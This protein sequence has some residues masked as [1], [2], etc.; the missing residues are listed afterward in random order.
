MVIQELVSAYPKASIILVSFA[1]TLVMTLIT[2]HLTDQRRIKE[3]RKRAKEHQAK[4]KEIRKGGDM[5]EMKK[6]QSLMMEENMELMRHSMK[7][8]MY[9]AIPLLLVF[10]GIR[11]TFDPLLASW[12]W[13][14]IG[15]SI[16]SSIVLRK[17]MDVS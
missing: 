10:W 8:L 17:A 6:V 4:F 2:K 5:E 16:L 3:L 11:K 1:I 13:W 14:Y 15:T 12:L 9:T 7:P